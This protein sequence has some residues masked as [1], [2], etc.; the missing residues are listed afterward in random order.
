MLATTMPIE[1]LVKAW[2]AIL[3]GLTGVTVLVPAPRR[4]L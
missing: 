4:L 2:L 1:V 3:V